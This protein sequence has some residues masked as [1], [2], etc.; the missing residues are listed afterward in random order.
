M[1]SSVSMAGVWKSLAILGGF[2]LMRYKFD[3]LYASP[4]CALR[5]VNETDPGGYSRHPVWKDMKYDDSCSGDN[6]LRYLENQSDRTEAILINYLTMAWTTAGLLVVLYEIFK[7]LRTM[8]LMNVAINVV[9]STTIAFMAATVVLMHSH[10]EVDINFLSGGIVHHAFSEKM[11]VDYKNG[12]VAQ[13][14]LLCGMVNRFFYSFALYKLIQCSP[15]LKKYHNSILMFAL[16]QISVHVA[17]STVGYQ[18]PVYHQM[19][20]ESMENAWPYT[21][22]WRAYKHV[23]VH[24]GNGESFSGDFFLDPVWDAQMYLYGYL[25]NDV[26]KLTVGSAAHYTFAVVMDMLMGTIGVA[27]VYA[28]LHIGALF[29]TENKSAAVTAGEGKK[30]KSA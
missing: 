24:H 27:V 28:Y 23:V 29:L 1:L 11:G 8:K 13:G 18:H 19:T 9:V 30:S 5:I 10:Y 6:L 7:S 16:L 15:R 17:L 14:Y 2:L 3:P 25:H 26:L 21:L 20:R 4:Q 12:A 22:A